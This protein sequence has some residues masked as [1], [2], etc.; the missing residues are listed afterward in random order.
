MCSTSYG[1]A[2]ILPINGCFLFSFFLESTRPD[3][4]SIDQMKVICWTQGIRTM[5]LQ[6]CCNIP[7]A[8][9]ALLTLL[10]PTVA[11][12]LSPSYYFLSQILTGKSCQNSF[13]SGHQGLKY[14]PVQNSLIKHIAKN[15]LN[16]LVTKNVYVLVC[17]TFYKIAH[18]KLETL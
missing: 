10:Q 14:T 16:H 9:T 8:V 13:S 17:S 15:S 1:M 4:F 11:S 7:D 12:R 3:G 5:S 18:Q 6:R 2:K